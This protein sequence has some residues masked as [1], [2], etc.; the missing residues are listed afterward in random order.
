MRVDQGSSL[1]PPAG[2]SGYEDPPVPHEVAEASA[3]ELL[4]RAQGQG[5]CGLPSLLLK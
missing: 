4:S 3:A 5:R 1:L 2:F